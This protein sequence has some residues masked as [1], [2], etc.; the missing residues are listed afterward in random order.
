MQKQSFILGGVAAVH[1][2]RFHPAAVTHDDRALVPDRRMGKVEAAFDSPY[3][4]IRSAWAYGEDGKWS[5]TFTIPANTSA[6]VKLPNGSVE[7]LPAGTYTRV[8]D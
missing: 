1:D 4:E 6:T 3:G 2:G 5:W 8:C 7:E